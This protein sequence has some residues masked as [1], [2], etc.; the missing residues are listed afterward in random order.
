[1]GI[2]F[3]LGQNY[4]EYLEIDLQAQIANGSINELNLL[5][6]RFWDINGI[7]LKRTPFFSVDCL[8][9]IHF[10]QASWSNDKQVSYRFLSKNTLWHLG[11]LPKTFPKVLSQFVTHCSGRRR[12]APSPLP[13][14]ETQCSTFHSVNLKTRYILNVLRCNK[15]PEYSDI[16]FKEIITSF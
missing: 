5:F 15:F 11:K 9:R 7:I 6:Y 14:A 8:P 13:C 2:G 10:I 16:N 4:S 12:L 1:M 3:L